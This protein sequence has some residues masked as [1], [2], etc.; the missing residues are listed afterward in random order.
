MNRRHLYVVIK[1]IIW[2]ECKHAPNIFTYNIL[3][4]L[5]IS[6]KIQYCLHFKNGETDSGNV[7]KL[8]ITIHLVSFKMII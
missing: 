3:F 6:L 1:S 5:T 2:I 4:V 7:C 8:K